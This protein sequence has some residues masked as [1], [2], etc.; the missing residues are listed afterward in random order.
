MDSAL[1]TENGPQGA[2]SVEEIFSSGI[3]FINHKVY[4]RESRGREFMTTSDMIRRYAKN[5]ISVWQS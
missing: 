1:L 5:R 3:V 2:F 4:N